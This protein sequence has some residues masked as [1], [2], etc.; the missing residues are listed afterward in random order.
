MNLKLTPAPT[1]HDLGG[2]HT[3][4][5]FDVGYM[6]QHKIWDEDACEWLH[7]RTF[8][9]EREPNGNVRIAGEL[10]KEAIDLFAMWLKEKY[11]YL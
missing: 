1:L 4:S 9:A 8:R 3:P 7:G 11:E 2:S 10:P 6:C 5:T